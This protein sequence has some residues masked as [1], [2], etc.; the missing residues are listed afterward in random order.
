MDLEG[1]LL[2]TGKALKN[3]A[4]ALREGQN[5]EGLHTVVPDG[6]PVPFR[7]AVKPASPNERVSPDGMFP[8][9]EIAHNIFAC[10]GY[11]GAGPAQHARLFLKML[12]DAG[13]GLVVTICKW[14]AAERITPLLADIGIRHILLKEDA[15]SISSW[16]ALK[17]AL[18][19]VLA[20]STT[21]RVLL[22]GFAHKPETAMF[23]VAL[24]VYSNVGM[25]AAA[26]KVRPFYPGITDACKSGN[27]TSAYRHMLEMMEGVRRDNPYINPVPEVVV[28]EDDA[29]R[30]SDRRRKR[31]CR[32]YVPEQEIQDGAGHSASYM[33][34]RARKP[35]RGPK[36]H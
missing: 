13:I 5:K 22:S 33:T 30:E 6:G 2:T 26:A 24:L 32:I 36:N 10:N 27:R 12:S 17:P 3:L 15:S 35:P 31:P 8:R 7:T 14:T 4:K 28:D 16:R 20:T 18:D 25:T 34:L 19:D 1:L 23:G 9:T 21:R 29:E 11:L